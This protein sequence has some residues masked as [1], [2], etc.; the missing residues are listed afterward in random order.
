MLQ[1]LLQLRL[2]HLLQHQCLLLFHLPEQQPGFPFS[3][4]AL[5]F[6]VTEYRIA[7]Y[8]T[9]PPSLY[10]NFMGNKRIKSNT[11]ARRIAVN[12]N[13]IQTPHSKMKIVP[14]QMQ[15]TIAFV[16]PPQFVISEEITSWRCNV[17]NSVFPYC[18]SGNPLRTVFPACRLIPHTNRNLSESDG[19]GTLFL[20]SVS[21]IFI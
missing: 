21:L 18:H 19:Y 1:V 11:T 8:S 2:H 13:F 5:C 9:G 10:C 12:F 15:R 17:R 3:S 20:P 16:V 7:L 6:F 4:A 14:C